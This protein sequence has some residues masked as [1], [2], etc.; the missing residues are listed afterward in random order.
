MVQQKDTIVALSTAPGSSAIA[1]LRLSGV[2][3]FEICNKIFIAK[4][5]VPD[6]QSHTSQ[7]GK[8]IEKDRTIDEVLLAKFSAPKTY[9]GEDIVEIS[10]HGSMYIVQ[11]VLELIQTQGARLATAGEF[12]QRAFM[13]G[14]LDLSQAEAVADLIASDNA[15]QH[16]IAMQ[17]LRGGYS[18]ELK[19]MRE[20]LI[21]FCALIE[22][23]LDFSEEDVEFADRTQLENLLTELLIKLNALAESFKFGNAI[24]KGV[25]VAIVGK[26]NVGK[27]TLLN[28]L[29]NEERAIVSSIA[30]TT[31]DTIEDVMQIEGISFRF[32]D[33]AGIRK[34]TDEIESKG[35]ERSLQKIKEAQIVLLL[36]DVSEAIEDI[37]LEYKNLALDEE[38]HLVIVVNK[39]DEFAH[40]LCNAYD[41]EEAIATKTKQTTLAISAK[42][43][44]HIDKLKNILVDA[45]AYAKHNSNQ[46][47]VSNSRHHTAIVQTIESLKEVQQAMA[48][49]VS[50]ELISIDLRRALSSLGSITGDI[51]VDR[52]ILGTIFGKFCIGK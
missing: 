46:L 41:V 20:K 13:N 12:T 25:P 49:K 4:Q 8:I 44:L 34:T 38:Q 9:T 43:N 22:L 15:A 37:I 24:K 33:T 18:N 45:M 6:M 47:V 50:G 40:G 51:E 5:S 26:P 35:I 28:S 10:C 23:E 30:G 2:N 11:E 42:N 29:L 19:A 7:F 39:A 14:K 36:C 31:R 1:V 17:Q 21:N 32:I 48:S 27:S 52:D 16:K 3:A